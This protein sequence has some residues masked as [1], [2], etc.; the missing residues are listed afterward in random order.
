MVDTQA[1]SEDLQRA[2]AANVPLLE[3]IPTSDAFKKA[4]EHWSGIKYED[5]RVGWSTPI[6]LA[7]TIEYVKWLEENQKTGPDAMLAPQ[8]MI[9]LEIWQTA[10]FDLEQAG[11]EEFITHSIKEYQEIKLALIQ[12]RLPP[13]FIKKKQHFWQGHTF[14]E[15]QPDY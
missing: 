6:D 2:E 4:W 1:A 5:G 8:A 13:L 7:P 9:P 14:H 3:S 15:P 10:D 11:I 12:Y